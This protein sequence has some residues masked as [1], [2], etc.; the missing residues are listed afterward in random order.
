[1]VSVFADRRDAGRRLAAA[2]ARYAAAEAPAEAPAVVLALPRGGVIVAVPVARALRLPLDL[3]IARKV[4]HPAWSEFAV[5]AV[6]EGGELVIDPNEVAR[7]D[8]AAFARAVALQRAEAERRRWLYLGDVLRVALVGKTAVVVDDGVAT[9]LTMR[10]ALR[11]V[12][13]RGAARIVVA[14]PVAGRDAA[15]LLATETD[16]FITLIPPDAFAGAVGAHYRSFEQVSDE[17]VV[18]ALAAFRAEATL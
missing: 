8:P 7:L 13:A 12:R 3:V 10:A 1:M 16:A 9:G 5:A 2:L 4:P 6:S 17:Q 15:A 18:V 11:D 14:V